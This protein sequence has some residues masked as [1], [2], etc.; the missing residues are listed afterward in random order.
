MRARVVKRV[1]RGRTH[2]RMPSALPQSSLGRHLHFRCLFLTPT[3]RHRTSRPPQSAS[4]FFDFVVLRYC[5]AEKPRHSLTEARGGWA[6]PA[7][8]SGAGLRRDDVSEDG[9]LGRACSGACR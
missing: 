9:D 1:I 8:V 3:H 7:H 4:S 6:R 5:A 2:H